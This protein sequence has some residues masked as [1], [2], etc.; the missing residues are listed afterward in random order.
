M[1]GRK[2]IR[3]IQEDVIRFISEKGSCMIQL[4][5]GRGKSAAIATALAECPRFRGMRVLIVAPRQVA[6]NTWPKEYPNWKHLKHISCKAASGDAA[7]RL[8]LLASQV[9]AVTISYNNLPWFFEGGIVRFKDPKRLETLKREKPEAYRTMFRG[10]GSNH[11]FDVIVFDEMQ[12]LARG[13]Q[14]FKLFRKYRNSFKYVIGTT[15]TPF[16]EGLDRAWAYAQA[17][18]PGTFPPSFQQ[19]QFTYFAAT[20]SRY[21]WVIKNGADKLI[22]DAIK[23]W[24]LAVEDSHV[25]KPC[26]SVTRYYRVDLGADALEKYKILETEQVLDFTAK[27]DDVIKAKQNYADELKRFKEK[28]PA[29][30]RERAAELFKDSPAAKAM[31]EAKRIE[32]AS[33]MSLKSKLWQMASGFLYETDET[34]LVRTAHWF[35]NAKFDALEQLLYGYEGEQIVIVY[36]FQAQLEKLLERPW[37]GLKPSERLEYVGKG[38]SAKQSEEI[39]RR[40]N[41]GDIPLLAI[42]PASMSEGVNL[43]KSGAHHMIFLCPFWSGEKLIQMKGRLARTGQVAPE[44]FFHFLSAKGTSDKEMED[45]LSGKLESEEDVLKALRRRVLK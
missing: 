24:F 20:K 44:V 26:K 16:T 14:S 39:V 6:I 40:W 34:S 42:H 12:H 10:F 36:W 35:S 28:L 8:E 22:F 43:Q 1:L 17:I 13:N 27:S 2:D 15:G 37:P 23:P 3:D 11:T 38:I 7:Q 31:G 5:V 4:A 45:V 30:M 41:E 29:M 19:F 18:S 9:Q 21:K 32:A 33:R 25:A